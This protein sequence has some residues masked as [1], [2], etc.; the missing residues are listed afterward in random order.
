MSNASMTG[1]SGLAHQAAAF[2]YK[3]GQSVLTVRALAQPSSESVRSWEND[4]RLDRDAVDANFAPTERLFRRS[5]PEYVQSTEIDS[6]ALSFPKNS[7]VSFNREKLAKSPY[8]VVSK[9]PGWRV[10]AITVAAVSEI[11]YPSEGS[12]FSLKVIHRPMK[13][14]PANL[15]D[16]DANPAHT[17]VCA[18]R[19]TAIEFYPATAVRKHLRMEIWRRIQLLPHKADPTISPTA[20]VV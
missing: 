7:G 8:E 9:H 5:P 16:P 6:A 20:S 15:K 4:P 14:D 3:Y 12:F 11:S 2:Q 17:E 10:L 19:N 1:A 13:A 18:H